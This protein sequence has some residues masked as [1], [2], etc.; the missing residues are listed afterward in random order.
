MHGFNN[1]FVTII[2]SACDGE[3]PKHYLNYDMKYNLV[4][5]IVNRIR[6]AV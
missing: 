5:R 2:I 4:L 1:S 3:F 6:D